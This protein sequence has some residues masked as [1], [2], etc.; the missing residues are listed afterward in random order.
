MKYVCTGRPILLGSPRC[1]LRGW[2]SVLTEELNKTM[3]YLFIK[4]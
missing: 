2:L 1:Q 4:S 3:R